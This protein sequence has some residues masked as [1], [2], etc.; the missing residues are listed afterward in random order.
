MIQISTN[1]VNKENVIIAGLGLEANG[2]QIIIEFNS[3]KEDGIRTNH[4]KVEVVDTVYAF[5]VG[6]DSDDRVKSGSDGLTNKPTAPSNK[7]IAPS[8]SNVEG[9]VRTSLD[10]TYDSLGQFEATGEVIFTGGSVPTGN[11]YYDGE[12]LFPKWDVFKANNGLPGMKYKMRG[13]LKYGE[14]GVLH[15]GATTSLHHIGLGKHDITKID[16]FIWAYQKQNIFSKSSDFP[17]IKHTKRYGR[18]W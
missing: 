12:N 16:V 1:G 7:A 17:E 6:G 11:F 8:I 3:K 5:A 13:K 14:F 4:I 9:L 10:V 15:V 2:D 18:F